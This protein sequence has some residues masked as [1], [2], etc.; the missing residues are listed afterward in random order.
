MAGGQIGYKSKLYR[1]GVRIP[2]VLKMDPILLA[3]A[4]I[5]SGDLDSPNFTNEYVRGF[6]D[7][8]EIGIDIK[9]VAGNAAQQQLIID[10]YAG[11]QTVEAWKVEILNPVTEAIVCTEDFPAYISSAGIGPLERATLVIIPLKLQIAGAIT[12]AF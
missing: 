4:K 1:V 9:F 12:P 2:N 11:L 5:D 10:A 7:P 3:V 6:S 8:P